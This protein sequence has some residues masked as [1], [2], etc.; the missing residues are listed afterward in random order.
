MKEEELARLHKALSV[1]VRLK[2]IRLIS[3][4]PL[5]VNAITRSLQIS[6]PAVSQ[7]LA[8]LRQADLVRG[9]KRGYMV[10]YTLNRARLQELRHAVD[11]FPEEP[12]AESAE[13]GEAAAAGDPVP[14]VAK[15][16]S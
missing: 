8:V 15:M 13:T 3:G 16:E 7:H 14:L 2:I 10:H 5:C 9:E 6:Q 1:P 12:P 4:R 11:S